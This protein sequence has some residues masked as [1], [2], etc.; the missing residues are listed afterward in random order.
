MNRDARTNLRTTISVLHIIIQLV[1]L[2]FVF[3]SG[4]NIKVSNE[5]VEI[6]GLY[7]MMSLIARSFMVFA[8]QYSL[9]KLFSI[10]HHSH[11]KSG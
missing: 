8:V 2:W 5:A 11:S 4:A 1:L 7:H 3:D 6:A 10:S 9:M